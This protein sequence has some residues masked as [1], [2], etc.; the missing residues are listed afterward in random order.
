MD[1]G[2]PWFNFAYR[3]NAG[4]SSRADL[5]EVLRK[6]QP[7]PPGLQPLI[8]DLLEGKRKFRATGPKAAISDD[9]IHRMG[10]FSALGGVAQYLKTQDVEHLNSPWPDICFPNPASDDDL[11]HLADNAKAIELN[12]SSVREVAIEFVAERLGVSTR[13]LEKYLSKHDAQPWIE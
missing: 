7:M 4:E 3:V 1:L 2:N 6:N 5:L 9:L 13:T 10:V 11:T 8:A 12:G